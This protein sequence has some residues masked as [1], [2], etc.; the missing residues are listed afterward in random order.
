AA[1]DPAHRPGVLFFSL[2]RNLTVSGFYTSPE[3]LRDMG[4]LGNRPNQWNGVPEDE[5]ERLGVYYSEKELRECVHFDTASGAGTDAGAA[6]ADTGTLR[7][8]ADTAR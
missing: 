7:G 8:G 6:G 4:Y 1:A 3:G 5:Q 2:M